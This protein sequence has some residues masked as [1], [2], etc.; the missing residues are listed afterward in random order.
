MYIPNFLFGTSS[1]THRWVCCVLF[2]SIG[3]FLGGRNCDDGLVDPHFQSSDPEECP[4]RHL[5]RPIQQPFRPVRLLDDRLLLSVDS[6]QRRGYRL[7]W[8]FRHKPRTDAGLSAETSADEMELQSDVPTVQV[9]TS[10]RQ[11]VYV[12]TIFFEIKKKQR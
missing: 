12:F 8:Y 5:Q 6:G 4:G 3:S 11:T 1:R 10:V 9:T 2:V 7:R